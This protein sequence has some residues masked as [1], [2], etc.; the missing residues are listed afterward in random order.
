MNFGIMG[1]PNPLPWSSVAIANKASACIG[2]H[3]NLGLVEPTPSP[4]QS[5]VHNEKLAPARTRR[6][7]TSIAIHNDGGTCSG[8]G[9]LNGGLIFGGFGGFSAPREE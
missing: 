8:S 2:G 3:M 1:T 4:V 5:A 6:I 7:Q 9:I